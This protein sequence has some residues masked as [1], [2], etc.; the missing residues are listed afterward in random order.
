[1]HFHQKCA[2]EPRCNVYKRTRVVSSTSCTTG[3]QIIFEWNRRGLSEARTK[4]VYRVCEWAL[5]V[6]SV[7]KL[8][9]KVD[10]I[11]QNRHLVSYWQV[12][13]SIPG[14]GSIDFFFSFFTHFSPFFYSVPLLFHSNFQSWQ[15]R[16]LPTLDP[17]VFLINQ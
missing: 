12:P 17:Y 4:S 14:R 16:S 13:G 2:L 8:Y 7:S 15:M 5:L 9:L 3:E 1:M 6:K 11:C 10:L